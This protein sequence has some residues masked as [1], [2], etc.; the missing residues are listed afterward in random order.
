V[1]PD[2]VGQ[3]CS[4]ANAAPPCSSPNCSPITQTLT[5]YFRI[6]TQVVG[7]RNTVS[8]IQVIVSA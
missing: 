3:H 6:T 4:S 5:P 2:G 7:P 8:Y 1:S